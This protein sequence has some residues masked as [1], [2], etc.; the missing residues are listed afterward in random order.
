MADIFRN[1]TEIDDPIKFVADY[2]VRRGKVNGAIKVELYD[3]C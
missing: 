2:I 1:K 3:D